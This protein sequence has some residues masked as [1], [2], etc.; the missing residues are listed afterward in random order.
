MKKQKS[1]S[2][3][4]VDDTSQFAK[5]L[6]ILEEQESP[7]SISPRFGVTGRKPRPKASI[8]QRRRVLNVRSIPGLNTLSQLELIENRAN[9]LL[10]KKEQQDKISFESF[11]FL[12]EPIKI[13][14]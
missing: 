5:E 6:Q 13:L 11:Y 3:P 14:G 2:N 9:A 4:I 1:K 7:M 10:E 12:D 8:A